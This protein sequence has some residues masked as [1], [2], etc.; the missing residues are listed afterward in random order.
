[1]PCCSYLQTHV[2]AV[3]RNMHRLTEHELFYCSWCSPQA[4]YQH[5]HRCTAKSFET[6]RAV[7]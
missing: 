6:A 1:M 4:P 5:N 2:C 3:L 7:V